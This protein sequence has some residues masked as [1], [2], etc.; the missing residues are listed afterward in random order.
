[1]EPRIAMIQ[2]CQDQKFSNPMPKIA[3]PI[4]PP[5]SAPTTPS[6]RVTNQPPPCFP[7]KMALAMAP[8]I[9]PNM[10][11]PMM[12]MVSTFTFGFRVLVD[13]DPSVPGPQMR[14][15]PPAKFASGVPTDRKTGHT[16]CD[17]T[18]ASSVPEGGERSH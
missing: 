7:G 18:T 9:S 4:Q 8:A 6:S 17:A 3:D 11:Q 1:M 16:V 5:R 13:D 10:I 12:L 2:V 15:N 14:G